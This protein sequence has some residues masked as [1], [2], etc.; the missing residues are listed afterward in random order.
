ME[1]RLHIRRL[2]RIGVEL[3]KRGEFIGRFDTRDID[4][5]GVFVETRRLNLRLNAM[6][7]LRFVVDRKDNLESRI[8]KAM[9]VHQSHEGVGLMFCNADRGSLNMR[10]ALFS[11]AA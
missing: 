4:P 5:G 9:V 7:T 6:M 8:L 2:F 1:H 11:A 3:Y 10:H